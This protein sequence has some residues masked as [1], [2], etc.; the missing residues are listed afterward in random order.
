MVSCPVIA[1]QGLLRFPADRK[2]I[3]RVLVRREYCAGTCARFR[4]AHTVIQT[5][6]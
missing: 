4:A 3:H 6:M 5:R 2:S 1:G